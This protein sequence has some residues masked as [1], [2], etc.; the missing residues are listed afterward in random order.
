MIV[1]L[2]E[3][4]ATSQ[5]ILYEQIKVI[6]K[7]AYFILITYAITAGAF[8]FVMWDVASHSLLI[9]WGMTLLLVLLLRAAIHYRYHHKLRPANARNFGLYIVI[10]LGITGLVWG[11]GVAL[12]FPDLELGYQFFIM[13]IVAG[14]GGSAF[15]SNTIF[16][17]GLYAFFPALL[18]PLAV[19]ML[20]MDQTLYLAMGSVTLVFMLSL[21][22]FSRNLNRSLVETLR[23]R[24]ENAELVKELR[25]QKEEAEHANNAK[26]KFLAAAS[27]DLRQPLHALSLFTSVLDEAVKTPKVRHVIEQI[28]TSVNALQGLFNAL[29]DISRLDAGVMRSE[30]INFDLKP[31]LSKLLNEYTPL[32]DEKKLKLSSLTS[33]HVVYSDP[34]LLEQIL[35]NYIS[36]AI[37][38]SGQGEIKVLCTAKE[39]KIIIQVID[40][41]IGIPGDQ[42]QTIFEEFHQL[43][44]PE[45]DRTKGLGLGLAIVRRTAK[46]LQ[47]PINVVSEPGKGSTFEIIVETGDVN[48]SVEDAPVSSFESKA[49]E[50][51]EILVVVIDDEVSVREGMQ[52]LLTSWG[53][54]V[55][56]ASDQEQALNALRQQ[57]KVPDAIIADYR[58]RENKTGIDA[59]HAIHSEFNAEI[60]ALI[61]TGDTAIEHLRN[62]SHSGFQVLHK[63]VAPLKLRTYLENIK[64]SKNIPGNM[65]EST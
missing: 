10:S 33:S 28:N 18:L 44:N 22:F 38:Y 47:H 32:A 2:T 58:L 56:T 29:L 13:F 35:R 50:N 46:L 60:S 9:N 57:R 23:L 62:V 27:H 5:T 39:D 63:P 25:Q 53:C 17:P 4:A 1:Q 64:L 43:G 21:Y 34:L 36:N 37:R 19:R 54:N 41:G 12:M 26:S 15:S 16:L 24:F 6:L 11:I 55:V 31:L 61:V 20:Y 30:K 42:L 7:S 3:N 49:G 65:N 45:R 40:T 8:L 59:I 14:I 51:Q 48:E 52:A